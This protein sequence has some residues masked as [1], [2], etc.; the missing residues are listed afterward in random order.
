MTL[1][2]HLNWRYA[3]KNYTDKKVKEQDLNKIIESINLSASSI[4]LQSYRLFLVK[5]KAIRKALREKSFN[6]Q[7]EEA[8]DLLVFA[9]YENVTPQLIDDYIERIAQEREQSTESLADFKSSIANYTLNR[10]TEENFIWSTK[11]AY[12]ALGTAMIAAAELKIDST[13]MEGFDNAL[14]DELL[15]LKQKGLKS[16]VLLALGYRDETK[17]PLANQKKVRLPLDEFYAAI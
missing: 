1:Q 13:P 7:I 8:S 9:A 14:V 4:G 12:I 11:Q 6:A 10:S 2:D 15:G 3:V 16:V 17:D 5:D